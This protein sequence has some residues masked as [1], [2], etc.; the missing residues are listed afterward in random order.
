MWVGVPEELGSR[1]YETNFGTFFL[2]SD[3]DMKEAVG[4]KTVEVAIPEHTI[5]LRAPISDVSQGDSTGIPQ[6]IAASAPTASISAVQAPSSTT[7]LQAGTALTPTTTTTI[8]TTTTT[9]PSQDGST[10]PSTR[11]PHTPDS[12]GGNDTEDQD[13]AVGDTVVDQDTENQEQMDALQFGASAAGTALPSGI[14]LPPAEGMAVTG[15]M[16][17]SGIHQ[18]QVQEIEPPDPTT[19]K[20]STS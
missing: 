12:E 20:E 11:T 10:D 9:T 17:P 8:T 13:T 4:M 7:T 3:K 18:P 19:W 14:H 16:L 6:S 15:M 5:P 2:Q 1:A